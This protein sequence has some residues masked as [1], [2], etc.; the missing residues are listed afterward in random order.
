MAGDNNPAAVDIGFLSDVGTGLYQ[1]ADGDGGLAFATAGKHAGHFDADQNLHVQNDLIA[2]R[3]E[4]GPANFYATVEAMQFL[5]KEISTAEEPQKVTFAFAESPNSG[6]M[7]NS[8]GG[9]YPKL[10]KGG[11]TQMF[12]ASYIGAPTSIRSYDRSAADPNFASQTGGGCGMWMNKAGSPATVNFST[13]AT[14]RATINNYGLNIEGSLWADN[15]ISAQTGFFYTSLHIGGHTPG[16]DAENAKM[17]K[18]EQIGDDLSLTPGRLLEQIPDEN[19]FI[20]DSA[21]ESWPSRSGPHSG[22]V[23]AVTHRPT[24]SSVTNFAGNAWLYHRPEAHFTSQVP[25]AY[26]VLDTGIYITEAGNAFSQFSLFASQ[27]TIKTTATDIEPLAPAVFN[28]N[29]TYQADGVDA[30]TVAVEAALVFPISFIS[31]P[32]FSAVD[33]GFMRVDSAHGL[34]SRLNVVTSGAGSEIIVTEFTDVV[35]G[36]SALSGAGTET[37]ESRVAFKILEDTSAGVQTGIKSLIPEG[38]GNLFINHTGGA[39]SVHVGDFYIQSMLSA[40]TIRLTGGHVDGY[41]KPFIHLT[42]TSGSQQDL[43][44]AAG[45]AGSVVLVTWDEQQHVD[46][47][48]T[49]S[50]SV[51]PSRITVNETGRYVIDAFV[52]GNNGSA[53]G[54]INVR[55]GYSIDGGTRSQR[56]G[57]KSYS[58]GNVWGLSVNPTLHTEVMMAAGSYFEFSSIVEMVESS[59]LCLTND[60]ECEFIMRKIS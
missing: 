33:S 30:G 21:V 28:S 22:L 13:D 48:F 20:M 42:K 36:N 29:Y 60:D 4:A 56:G 38:S 11:V 6:M 39:S 23:G 54:R 8:G 55:G 59:Q 19:Y 3:I 2:G 49:H 53:A 41:V 17:W 31:N 26:T 24:T 46:T 7:W 44:A 45:G 37:I 43:A 35:C 58:R 12:F 15:E 34:S 10:M 51:N 57:V 40:D 27:S 16:G 47:T 14:N 1:F 9:G 18:F 32:I 25:V 5:G 52:S 50:T